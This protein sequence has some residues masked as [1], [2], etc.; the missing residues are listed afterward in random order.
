[1][2]FGKRRSVIGTQIQHNASL[3]YIGRGRGGARR[4][5]ARA[6]VLH[7]LPAV[8]AV[9]VAAL[10]L[11]GVGSLVQS[12]FDPFA[13]ASVASPDASSCTAVERAAA[14]GIDVPPVQ[15]SIQ[16]T[17]PGAVVLGAGSATSSGEGHVTFS[18]VGDNIANENLLELADV[19]AGEVGDDQYDFNAFYDGIRDAVQSYDISFINQETTLGGPDRYGYNGYPSFNTPDSMADAIVGAGWDVVSINSNHTYDTGEPAVQ[20][21]LGV[22]GAKANDVM[23][24]GSFANED[25]RDRVRMVERNGVRIAFLSY[26]YGQNG[27]DQDELPNDYYAVPYVQ[28]DMQ[29]DVARAR[30]VADAVVVYMHWGTEYEHDPDETQRAWAQ[31]L[32]DAGVDLVIGSHAHVIQPMEWVE[33]AGGKTLVVYGLGDVWSGYHDKPECILSGMFTCE[34]VCKSEKD[35]KEEGRAVSIENVAWHPL[36]EHWEDGADTVYPLSDYTE[37]QASANELLAG[38]DDPYAWMQDLTRQVIGE[39]FTVV[40]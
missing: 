13:S 11:W 14:R 22:W 18:A 2:R 4:R 29:A 16:V 12:G 8:V 27:Y 38:L 5:A 6:N 36:V 40:M 15:A 20:H 26:S 25:E 37:K 39:D 21:S 32:A 28:E 23:A 31:E 19:A 17:S 1:M 35:A 34:F 30:K 7:A 10:G 33:G 24:I 3:G 9:A